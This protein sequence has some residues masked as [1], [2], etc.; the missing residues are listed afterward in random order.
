MLAQHIIDDAVVQLGKLKDQADKAVAQITTEQMFATIDAEANSIAL[1]MKHVSGNM[2]SRWTDFLTS[3]GEKPNRNRDVEFE[4]EGRDTPEVILAAWE[5]AWKLTLDAVSSL[6][7]EDLEKTVR[8]RGQ[9]HT[10]VQAIN[11]QLS[12]YAGHVGQIVLL[13]KHYAGNRWQTLS[14]P[15]RKAAQS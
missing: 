11:R 5:H 9:A 7:P 13:A 12:H 10:V 14:M 4:A 6:A 2:R 15:K 8:I 3:D 1:I